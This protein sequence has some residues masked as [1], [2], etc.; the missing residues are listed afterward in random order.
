MDDYKSMII[1]TKLKLFMQL[2]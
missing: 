2:F 1:H